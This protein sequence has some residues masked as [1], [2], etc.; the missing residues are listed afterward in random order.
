[1]QKISL[2][3]ETNRESGYTI[4]KLHYLDIEVLLNLRVLAYIVYAK[5]CE[6][7]IFIV[8]PKFLEHAVR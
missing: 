3:D 1:M 8:Q 4:C 5:A 2:D 7:N 6:Q